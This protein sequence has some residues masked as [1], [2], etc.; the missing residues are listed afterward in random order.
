MDH[1]KIQLN[2]HLLPWP[3]VFTQLQGKA[4]EQAYHD[5]YI[6]LRNKLIFEMLEEGHIFLARE[7]LQ[8][9]RRGYDILKDE[10]NTIEDG[11]YSEKMNFAQQSKQWALWNCE[12]LVAQWYFGVASSK[13]REGRSATWH[14]TRLVVS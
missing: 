12:R 10:I 1:S 6:A 11:W 8:E 3:L 9:S 14:G 2:E 4:N 5:E 13:M 7:I